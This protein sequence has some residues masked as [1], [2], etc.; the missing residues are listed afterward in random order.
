MPIID[1]FQ[2]KEPHVTHYIEGNNHHPSKVIMTAV[3]DTDYGRNC[4]YRRIRDI[5]AN[6]VF[7]KTEAIKTSKKAEFASPTIRDM[8]IKADRLSL[9]W[10]R[11]NLAI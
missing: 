7:T 5:F 1:R 9:K 3:E 8:R 10:K 2:G 11:I 6:R 4:I